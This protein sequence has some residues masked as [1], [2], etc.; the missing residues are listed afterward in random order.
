MAHWHLDVEL[1]YVLN[2]KIQVGINSENH[3]LYKGD[4]AICGSGD[5]HFY[6]SDGMESEVIIVIFRSDLIESFGRWPKSIHFI[7]PFICKDQNFYENI[8]KATLNRID[9]IFKL[10]F[11]EYEQKKSSYDM[12]LK[13]LLYEFCGISLRYI[14]CCSTETKKGSKIFSDIKAIQLALSY[15]EDKYTMDISLNEL[16]SQVHISP[17]HFSRLFSKICG[18]SFKLYLNT[19]RI[20]N[21]ETL[22]STTDMPIVD[23]ALECGFNSL[24][25]FNR[26]FKSVKGKT[27]SDVR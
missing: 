26:V 4:F 23:I 17:F 22:L 24:R 8:P 3:I 7:T 25:T 13:G 19:I 11:T 10:L 21:A 15:I 9:E 20:N 2:G 18:V 1:I 5:I 27:P 6:N 16:A 12:F 14:P